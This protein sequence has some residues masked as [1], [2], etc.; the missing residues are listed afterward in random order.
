[1]SQQ[2]PTR[3]SGTHDPAV[4]PNKAR[5]AIERLLGIEAVKT[6]AER[7][8][9]AQ[10]ERGHPTAE[11][12]QE[13]AETTPSTTVE[14][15]LPDAEWASCRRSSAGCWPTS[16]TG[17]AT[18]APG[19]SSAKPR[20]SVGDENCVMRQTAAIRRPGVADDSVSAAT[21]T[22]VTAA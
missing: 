22:P 6:P 17:Y 7:L 13:K 8:A 11:P 12:Q 21:G 2:S 20:G 10:A 3:L 15:T 14:S 4:G 19:T 16:P 9:V 5:A 18:G 1:M